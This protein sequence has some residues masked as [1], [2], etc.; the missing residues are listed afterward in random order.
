MGVGLVRMHADA[1]PDV[2]VLLG[3]G[4]DRIPFALAG[5][6]VEEAMNATLPCVLK[7]FVLAFDQAF[8]IEVAVAVDQPHAA[9]SSSSSSRGNSGV[10]WG[11]GAPSLPASISVSS[12]S[13]DS[14]MIG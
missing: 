6:D 14:G 13:A 5:G 11:I 3:N 4:D 2:V 7:H 9:S 10:G 1:G 8:V 12:L